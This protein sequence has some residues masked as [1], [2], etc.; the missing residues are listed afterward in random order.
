[1]CA[2]GHNK[3]RIKINPDVIKVLGLCWNHVASQ[4]HL[5]I[6]QLLDPLPKWSDKVLSEQ[7]EVS[8]E[9]E[10]GVCVTLTGEVGSQKWLVVLLELLRSWIDWYGP[11][12]LLFFITYDTN[13]VR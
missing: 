11:E 10:V 5:D 12:I 3:L 8:V 9:V 2:F 13:G 6:Q 1:M 7:P 4:V